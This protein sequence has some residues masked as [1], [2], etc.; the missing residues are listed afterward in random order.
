MLKYEKWRRD[1]AGRTCWYITERVNS[2]QKMEFIVFDTKT[3]KIILKDRIDS[4]HEDST[5]WAENPMAVGNYNKT[6]GSYL[7]SKIRNL[8]SNRHSTFSNDELKSKM[9]NDAFEIIAQK[10]S[11]KLYAEAVN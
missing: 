3:K 10:I 9:L 6:P 11:E 4:R 5:T 7:P 8:M 2:S 1:P